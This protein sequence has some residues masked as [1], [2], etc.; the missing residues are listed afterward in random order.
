MK[1]DN[2]SQTFGSYIRNL[3]ISLE[4]GQRQL[5][6]KISIAPSYLNDIEKSKRAAPK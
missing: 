1:K 6:Q 4:M 3:R 2:L 5:A